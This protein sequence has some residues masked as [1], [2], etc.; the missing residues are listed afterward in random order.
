MIECTPTSA[1][2]RD[3]IAALRRRQALGAAEADAMTAKQAIAKLA[4]WQARGVCTIT[5]H[6]TQ[7]YGTHAYVELGAAYV[8]WE[9][10][11][12]HCRVALGGTG[13]QSLKSGMR[14]IWRWNCIG[15]AAKA[16]LAARK[17]GKK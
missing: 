4:S 7:R 11:F 10:V 14:G 12:D 2:V 1:P 15:D 8:A 5:R 9:D 6:C 13:K 16:L 17:G 3:Q